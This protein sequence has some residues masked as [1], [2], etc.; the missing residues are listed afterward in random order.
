[1]PANT[2]ADRVEHDVARG[3]EQILVGFHELRGEAPFEEVAVVAVAPVEPLGIASIQV[4]HSGGDVGLRGPDQQV[5]VVAHLAERI[6]EPAVSF[7]RQ[8]AQAEV[9]PS[10]FAVDVDRLVAIPFRGDV[11]D[12]T[13]Y[14]RTERSCHV[15]T[16]A[17]APW[18]A[19]R[20]HTID[21]LDA[22]VAATTRV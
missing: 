15:T 4:L 1:M 10:A 6:A 12:A 7:D 13:R 2:G 3:F 16:V 5:V 18:C 17:P 22:S 8:R 20:R 14:L 19:T 11:V 21:P 9:L